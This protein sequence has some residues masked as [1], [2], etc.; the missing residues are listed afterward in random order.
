M[1]PVD[2]LLWKEGSS[3]LKLRQGTLRVGEIVF[4]MKRTLTAYLS[5]QSWNYPHTSNIIWTEQVL[6]TYLGKKVI[7]IKEAIN[8]RETKGDTEEGLEVAKERGIWY[9]YNFKNKN[10][11]TKI[12]KTMLI[13]LT[14][15]WNGTFR[16]SVVFYW[17]LLI[18]T[19]S[20]INMKVLIL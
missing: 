3:G 18:I 13:L 2:K 20:K 14:K 15:R 9:N 19:F 17:I 7:T 12:E 4:P 10:T 16:S 1:T 6:F 11:T 8:L 5:G